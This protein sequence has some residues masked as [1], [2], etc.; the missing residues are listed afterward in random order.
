LPPVALASNQSANVSS[1]VTPALYSGTTID[2]QIAVTLTN[3]GNI[4]GAVSN[5]ATCQATASQGRI[6]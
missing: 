5:G 1:T 3:G 4:S 2:L 6:P